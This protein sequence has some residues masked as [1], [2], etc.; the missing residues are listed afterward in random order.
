[1]LAT[2]I[3]ELF[4]FASFSQSWG[5]LYLYQET[6]VWTDCD[7]VTEECYILLQ[8]D[9]PVTRDSPVSRIIT[10]PAPAPLGSSR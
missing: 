10:A 5:E 9:T 8:R 1:M 4:E 7:L 6:Q 2:Y 3:L